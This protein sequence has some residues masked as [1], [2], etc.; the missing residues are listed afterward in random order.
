MVGRIEEI[1][2]LNDALYSNQSELIAIYG[3]RRIGKTFL[4]R[5]HF[6]KQLIFS[7]S[8]LYNGSLKEQLNEFSV[9]FKNATNSKFNFETPNDWFEAFAMLRTFIQSKTGK[10][11][12]VIFLDE[13]PWMCMPKS[14]FL[15]AFES[16]WNGWASG[17]KD[18][19]V[20]ICGSA[21]SWMIQK[22]EKSKGGLYNRVTKRLILKPFTLS[23]TEAFL[24][25]KRNY[26]EQTSYY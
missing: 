18:I 24:K 21:S 7:M 5:E 6:S 2:T 23:E 12:K 15:T 22:I 11:K 1:K 9:C 26:L 25:T 16:F 20:I 19:V 10:S 8:G 3:R 14:R 4:V 17:R 13:V